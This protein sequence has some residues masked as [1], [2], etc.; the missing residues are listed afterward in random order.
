MTSIYKVMTF[1]MDGDNNRD[2]SP[3]QVNTKYGS[4]R[5]TIV[6]LAPTQ[7]SNK[8]SVPQTLPSIEAYL[9]LL[10]DFIYLFNK[11]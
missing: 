9:G 1:D 11:I 2:L 5:G 4:L 6:T 3:R 10:T 7:S 8:H